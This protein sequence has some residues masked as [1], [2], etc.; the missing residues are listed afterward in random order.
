MRII[1]SIL[2]SILIVLGLSGCVTTQSQANKA[3]MSCGMVGMGD[4]SDM[5]TCPCGCGTAVPKAL[6]T[7]S[8]T[9][10]SS[11]CCAQPGEKKDEKVKK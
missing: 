7:S 2:I 1:I 3:T 4:K 8:D 11:S 6:L 5:G 9:T 10:M